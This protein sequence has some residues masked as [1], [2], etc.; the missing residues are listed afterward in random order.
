ML[1]SF[2]NA[3]RDLRHALLATA[4]FGAS[5]GIFLATLNNYLSEVHEL[6]AAARG[7]IE[8]PRELPGFLIIFVA[9]FMLVVLRESQMAAL[10][11][12]VSAIGAIGLGFFSPTI[13]A[14]VVFVALWS[15]G[16]HVIFAVEGPIGLKL[17]H[18]GREGR[19]LGSIK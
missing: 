2:L 3:P 7:W 16:D 9:G 1:R 11:M 6:N 19:R 5:S 8:L 10:A 12:V 18:G 4:F 15:L 14:L 13:A 17:A